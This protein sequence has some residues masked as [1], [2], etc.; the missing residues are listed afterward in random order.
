M[1]FSKSLLSLQGSVTPSKVSLTSLKS[2]HS[3]ARYTYNPLIKRTPQSDRKE[4]TPQSDRKQ[5]RTQDLRTPSKVEV[6][7]CVLGSKIPK[8]KFW[9]WSQILDRSRAEIGDLSEVLT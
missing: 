1:N 4:R 8:S 2:E 5:P 3:V 7:L 9:L 6:K